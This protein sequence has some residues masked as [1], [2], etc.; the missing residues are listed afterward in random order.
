MPSREKRNKKA[1]GDFGQ[2]TTYKDV[3][4]TMRQMVSAK[5]KVRI[6]ERQERQEHERTNAELECLFDD[7]LS[8]CPGLT[9]EQF[10][11]AYCCTAL[12]QLQRLV[13]KMGE[14]PNRGLDF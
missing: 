9:R 8:V 7:V 12:K 4:E 5:R 3:V 14:P 11:E 10:Y 1:I 6:R 2:T 13:D